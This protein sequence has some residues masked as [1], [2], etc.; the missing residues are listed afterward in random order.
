[1]DNLNHNHIKEIVKKN[2]FNT[3]KKK[4]LLAISGGIDSMLLLKIS[5]VISSE[6]NLSFRAIHINHNLS[7]NCKEMEKCCIKSCNKY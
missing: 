4:F 1:M 2:L 5:S 6:S 7:A 3:P